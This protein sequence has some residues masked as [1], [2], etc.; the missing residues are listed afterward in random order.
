[1]SKQKAVEE[2]AAS[3]AQ[4]TVQEIVA[5]ASETQ[6]PELVD[7]VK[8][9]FCLIQDACGVELIAPPPPVEPEPDLPF[10]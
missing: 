8:R 10:T 1:M 4:A 9:L 3:T 7:R 2:Y 6:D 5:L